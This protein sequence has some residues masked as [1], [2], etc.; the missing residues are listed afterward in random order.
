MATQHVVFGARPEQLG[1]RMQDSSANGLLHAIHWPTSGKFSAKFQTE[2]MGS[3]G[4]E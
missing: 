2:H 3:E 1:L 4:A